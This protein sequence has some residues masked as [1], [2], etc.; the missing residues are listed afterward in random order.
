[1]EK[2]L[3]RKGGEKYLCL[4]WA[5]ADIQN[6][7]VKQEWG[8]RKRLVNQEKGFKSKSEEETGEQIFC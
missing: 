3:R 2:N 6:N 5:R 7:T 1:M 8:E 4:G